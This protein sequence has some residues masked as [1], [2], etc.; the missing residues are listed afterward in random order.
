MT[1]RRAVVAGQF[2]PEQPKV[3]EEDVRGYI[4]ASGVVAS[5][6]QVAALV[7]PHAG[8]VYSGPTAG[9]AYARVRGAKPRRV[10]L[11]GRSHRYAFKGAS[12]WSAGG[13][14][15]PLGVLPVDTGMA[16]MLEQEFGGAPLEAHEVEHTLEVQ[17][18]FVQVAIGTVPIVPVLFGDE[19]G[20]WHAEFGRRLAQYLEPGDLVIAST[21]LSHYLIEAEA[22][23]IDRESIGTVLEHDPMRLVKGLAAG[24]CSMCGGAAVVAA[25]AYA[26]ARCAGDWRLLD[27]RTS[28]H[29]TGDTSHVVG[30]A[31]I[32]MEYD[33]QENGQ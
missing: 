14:E 11:M 25:M 12:I 32:S 10:V 1:V 4:D 2:Y 8:Y 5:P 20:E 28:A 7:V 24:T 26:N 6:G 30:Y 15:S 29:T 17:A 22:D 19:A 21:D 13:Y 18:P 31:A 27:H 3:L 16:A 9:F 33:E 23:V